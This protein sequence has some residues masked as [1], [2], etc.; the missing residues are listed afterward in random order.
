MKKATHQTFNSLEPYMRAYNLMNGFKK[1]ELLAWSVTPQIVDAFEASLRSTWKH[2]EYH[3]KN[4]IEPAIE[5]LRANL[6]C[7]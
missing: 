6:Q 2:N 4:V 1:S 3:L 5:A 7:K